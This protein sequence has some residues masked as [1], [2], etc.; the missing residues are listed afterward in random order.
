[1]NINMGEIVDYFLNA[2]VVLVGC[3]KELAQEKTIMNEMVSEQLGKHNIFHK[4]DLYTRIKSKKYAEWLEETIEK[5]CCFHIPKEK[6]IY[7]TLFEVLKEKDYFVITTNTGVSISQSDLEPG[8]IVSPCGNE[9]LFQCGENCM[10]EVWS[11]EEY[12]DNVM[13]HLSDILNFLEQE[14]YEKADE[15]LPKCKNCGE[16]AVYNVRIDKSSYSE[17]GYLGQWKIYLNWLQKTLNKKAVMLELGEDFKNP[18]VI[19]WPFEKNT[20]INQKAVL[21]RINEEFPQISEEIKD[22][23]FCIKM[24]SVDF[25]TDFLHHYK[26]RLK[27]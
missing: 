14:E 5:Y 16:R 10:D 19:R 2:E 17:Q 3:G 7:Q 25:L 8:R 9:G 12:L 11:S 20:L 1:M 26:E 23:A 6:N 27:C 24:N 15:Y 21:F 18:T 4:S 22:K 13:I